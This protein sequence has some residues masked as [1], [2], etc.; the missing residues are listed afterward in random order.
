MFASSC[1]RDIRHL[2]YWR[3]ARTHTHTRGQTPEY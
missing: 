2:W 1:K 3:T